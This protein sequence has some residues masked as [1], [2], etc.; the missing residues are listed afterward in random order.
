[1]G[2]GGVE[3]GLNPPRM[4][5]LVTKIPSP[6]RPQGKDQLE[7]VSHPCALSAPQRLGAQSG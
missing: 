7:Y 5:G 6:L 1:M 4:T 2:G 3:M